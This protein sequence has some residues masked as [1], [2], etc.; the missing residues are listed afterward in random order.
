MTR[1]RL[2]SDRGT[3]RARETLH[4][5]SRAFDDSGADQW[6]EWMAACPAADPPK[7]SA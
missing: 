2:Q 3:E 7:S 4:R 6:D 1:R 5:R